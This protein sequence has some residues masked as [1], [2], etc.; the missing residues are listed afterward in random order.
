MDVGN[1]NFNKI[2]HH[3][4]PFGSGRDDYR[5]QRSHYG[6]RSG[7]GSRYGKAT[8]NQ[9]FHNKSYHKPP[10]LEFQS[11]F[12]GYKEKPQERKILYRVSKKI[13]TPDEI[14][15]IR[16]QVLGASRRSLK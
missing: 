7:A 3:E 1:L 2:D 11:D 15:F 8:N 6:P 5:S 4:T 16:G 13:Y 10:S 12:G 9:S 14:E